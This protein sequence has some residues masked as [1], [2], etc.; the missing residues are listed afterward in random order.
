MIVGWIVLLVGLLAVSVVVVALIRTAIAKS[1]HNK[2]FESKNLPKITVDC[3]SAKVHLAEA[4]ACKT[5]GG[6]DWAMVDTG[7]FTRFRDVLREAYPLIHSKLTVRQI[8]TDNLVFVWE[9]SD[10]QAE[11]VLFCAHQDVV[12]AVEE[13]WTHSP[14]GKDISDGYVWGRG[15]F[16]MKGQLISMLEAVEQSLKEGV[17]IQR[18]LWIALG[19]D[20]E[21]RGEHG[22]KIIAQTMFDEHRRFAFV[23][24]EGGAV[25][26][27]FFSMLAQPVAVVGMAEKSYA[28]VR[29]TYR[30]RGGHSSTPEHPTPV[31]RLARAIHRIEQKRRPARFIAPVKAM[32]QALALES[33]LPIATVLY[34]PNLFKP[35]IVSL[36]SNNSTM[37]A[38]IRDTLAATMVHGSDAPNVIGT[39]ATANINVRMLCDTQLE[40]LTEWM[41]KVMKDE[42]I[43]VAVASSS[44]ASRATDSKHPN[45]EP[46]FYAIRETFS[47]AV[48]CPYIMT[49]GSDGLWYEQVSDCVVRFSPFVMD[50]NELGRMHANDERLSIDNLAKGIEFYRRLIARM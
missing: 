35:L 11:P 17:V 45:I 15:S 26:K 30:G 25:A 3:E 23:F 44:P 5:I 16:D 6:R 1:H 39:V 47:D 31:A 8:G 27:G 20:E 22:A 19:C 7:E 43:E 50:K 18:S 49:G 13:Q 28:D 4:I 14:F 48:V 29:L 40:E 2:F 32:M 34:N 46:F 38:L 12:P 41:K 37:N 33:P 42:Q 24:D 9:G 36:F 21:I 10:T